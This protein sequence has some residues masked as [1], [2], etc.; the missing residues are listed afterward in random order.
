MTRRSKQAKL[1]KQEK[2]Q[3]KSPT[4]VKKE[5]KKRKRTLDNP[6]PKDIQLILQTLQQMRQKVSQ[7]CDKFSDIYDYKVTLDD[8]GK[9]VPERNKELYMFEEDMLKLMIQLDSIQSDHVLVKENRR[10]TILEIQSKLKVLDEFKLD[11]KSCDLPVRPKPIP[12]TKQSKGYVGVLMV[13]LL[14]VV[15]G[16]GYLQYN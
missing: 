10:N 12:V 4:P 2:E 11:P 6:I 15:T 8:N 7:T 16:V 5:P 13:A 9:V 3:Q 1:A 14:A